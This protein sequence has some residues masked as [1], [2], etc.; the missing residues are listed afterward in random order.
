MPKEQ[1]DHPIYPPK[2]KELDSV[3]A[4]LFIEEDPTPIAV[5]LV[6]ISYTFENGEWLYQYDRFFL[7][8]FMDQLKQ[9]EDDFMQTQYNKLVKISQMVFLKEEDLY[10][11]FEEVNKVTK[12]RAFT[13][14]KANLLSK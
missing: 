7:K 10:S 9:N 4:V 8:I 1:P 6:I 11:D 5:P 3:I 2:F 14:L 13:I 12:L